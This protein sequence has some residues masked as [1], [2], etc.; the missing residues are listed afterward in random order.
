MKTITI[1]SYNELINTLESTVRVDDKVS[2][3]YYRGQANKDWKLIPSILRNNSIDEVSE[4]NNLF[5]I[6]ESDN[7]KLSLAA[8]QHYGKSTRCL[9]FTRNFRIALYFACNPNDEHYNKDGAIYVIEKIYHKPNWFTNY[10]MYYTA[11][12]PKKTI[13]NWEYTDFLSKIPEIKNE[14]I[15]TGRK[16]TIDNFDSEI[17][18]YLSK[19]FMVDFTECDCNLERINKQEAALY[20]FGSKYYIL[21]KLGNKKYVSID[22]LSSHCSSQNNFNIELHSLSNPELE[23]RCLFKIIIPQWLKKDIFNN[24]NI[25]ASDLGFN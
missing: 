23:K 9:D 13:S 8:A 3:L 18:V 5:N 25:S 11:T 14:F 20:Y 12:N 19:G 24:I 17:Q 6:N 10:L 22:Y 2:R 15:R 1:N 16:C 21:D 4:L 7:S